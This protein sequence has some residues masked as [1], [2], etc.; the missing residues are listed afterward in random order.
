[1]VRGVVTAGAA[2]VRTVDVEGVGTVA[3]TG[4]YLFGGMEG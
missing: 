4:S 3:G 1:M 2:V